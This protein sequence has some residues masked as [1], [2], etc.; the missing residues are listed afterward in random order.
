M[1]H[2]EIFRVV[3]FAQKKGR[4]EVKRKEKKQFEKTY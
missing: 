3:L 4:K 1:V 2:L